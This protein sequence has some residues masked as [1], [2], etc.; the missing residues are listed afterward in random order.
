MA[1]QGGHYTGQRPPAQSPTRHPA[2]QPSPSAR[3]ALRE[4]VS[5]E[6]FDATLN[7]LPTAGP[8]WPGS[9]IHPYQEPPS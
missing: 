6:H 7:A 2:R 5:A 8:P 4:G 1:L 3:R 9:P